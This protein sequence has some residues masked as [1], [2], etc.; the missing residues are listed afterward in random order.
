M[1]KNFFQISIIIVLTML[2]LSC[3]KQDNPSGTTGTGNTSSVFSISGKIV[4]FSIMD[5][6]YDIYIYSNTNIIKLTN[7]PIYDVQPFL[8]PDG[9]KVVFTRFLNMPT[10][11]DLWLYDFDLKSEQKLTSVNTMSSVSWAPDGNKI[12][13][14]KD[15]GSNIEI[16]TI[17]AN[18]NSETRLTY[19]TG[20]DILP[21]WSL[22]GEKIVF[23]SQKDGNQEIYV[24]NT[25][26]SIQNRLTNNNVKDE[27]P[28]WSPDGNKIAFVSYADESHGEIYI[29]NSDGNSKKRLTNNMSED[30][31]SEFTSPWS[32]D[33]SKLLFTSARDLN[34]EIYIMDSEGNNQTRLTDTDEEN[35]NPVFSPDENKIAFLRWFNNGTN[36]EIFI[37]NKDG[38]E[39]TR[40]TNNSES[41]IITGWR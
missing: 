21:E 22:V 13:F 38:T 14:T 39:Q 33:G 11:A 30:Y 34:E 35:S 23:C 6:D 41:D 5:G 36:A 31:F 25:D 28:K 40:I 29:M 4:F 32:K 8:S 1:K 15:V 3:S 37:M 16:F 24:M 17:D 12:A 27:Y 20:N 2:I 9:K 7:N 10:D 19:N 26:G 18:G